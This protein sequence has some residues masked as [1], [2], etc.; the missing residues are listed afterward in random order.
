MRFEKEE[1]IPLIIKR[2]EDGEMTE[3]LFNHES[4]NQLILSKPMGAGL[5]YD[6]LPS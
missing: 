6:T 2:Y 4:Q 1:V 3:K 5:K